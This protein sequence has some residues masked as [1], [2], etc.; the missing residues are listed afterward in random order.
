MGTELES[1][2]VSPCGPAGSVCMFNCQVW[3]RGR[4]N[5]SDR[6]RYSESSL[7]ARHAN[8]LSLTFARASVTQ[9]SYAS[10]L[11]G[12]KFFPFVNYTL[13]DYVMEGASDRLMRL[14]GFQP[15]G[16]YT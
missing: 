10:Y 3:H 6:T 11:V 8:A 2:V 5:D 1:E 15:R 16:A 14:L 7:G 9:I 13:P 12:H 4:P